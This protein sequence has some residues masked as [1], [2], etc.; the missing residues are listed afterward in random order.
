MIDESTL[1]LSL[2]VA[3]LSVVSLLSS[4]CKKDPLVSCAASC[5]SLPSLIEL[6]GSQLAVI[7]TVGFSDSILSYFTAL[8]FVFDGPPMLKYGYE[9]VNTSFLPS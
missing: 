4:L 7:P 5:S 6:G 8:R 9:K 3:S 2:L 1:R